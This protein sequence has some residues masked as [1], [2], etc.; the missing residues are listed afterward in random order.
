MVTVQDPGKYTRSVWP[1]VPRS[2]EEQMGL[3]A[4]G[5]DDLAAVLAGLFSEDLDQ[6]RVGQRTIRQIVEH[7]VDDDVRWTM[8]MQVALIMPGYT[9]G[10]AWFSSTR[11]GSGAGGDR[12]I[13]PLVTL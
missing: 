1:L 9:Y 8:C 7:V 4:Q 5:P 6:A 10:H 13:E 11:R 2:P 12:A 3:Y